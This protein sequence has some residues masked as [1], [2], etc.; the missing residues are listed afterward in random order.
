MYTKMQMNWASENVCPDG[1][2][3]P[4]HYISYGIEVGVVN[5]GF[6]TVESHPTWCEATPGPVDPTATRWEVDLEGGWGGE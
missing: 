2:G 4:L 6:G 3:C 1:G 5:R